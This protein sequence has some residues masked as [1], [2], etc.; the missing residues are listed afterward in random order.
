M[1]KFQYILPV[2]LLAA[3]CS[4][5]VGFPE[6]RMLFSPSL[7]GSGTKATETAFEASDAIGIY[8]VDVEAGALELSGNWANNARGVF[9]G[10]DWDVSPAIYWKGDSRFNVYAYYPYTANVNSVEDFRFPLQQDQS[11][12]GFTLS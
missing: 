3:S 8:A 10:Q 4:G 9:D 12:N 2:L 5:T 11:G 1:I 6:D 7:P